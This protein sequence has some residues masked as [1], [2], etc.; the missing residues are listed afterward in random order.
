MKLP[1]LEICLAVSGLSLIGAFGWLVWLAVCYD[2]QELSNRE[3]TRYTVQTV[4]GVYEDLQ[5]IST[6]THWAKYKRPTGETIIFNGDFTEI[7]Q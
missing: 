1:V 4:N 6:R 3:S 5:R 2:L 7:E